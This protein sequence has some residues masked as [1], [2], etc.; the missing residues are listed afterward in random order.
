[1]AEPSGEAPSLPTMARASYVDDLLLLGAILVGAIGE[2][3]CASGPAAT[4]AVSPAALLA[5]GLLVGFGTRM[6][7]G[8]TS[9]HG[10]TGVA[11]LRP[12][13]LVATAT[14]FAAGIATSYA[15]EALR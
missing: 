5:G 6:A 10:L 8:C 15:L 12:A 9:G 2:R 1:M 3:L 4:L 7:G 14:F 11:R 13:S